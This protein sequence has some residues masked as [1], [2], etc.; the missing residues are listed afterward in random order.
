[1][2][3]TYNVYPVMAEAPSRLV[4]PAGLMM[5]DCVTRGRRLQL[6]VAL[7]SHRA[8]LQENVAYG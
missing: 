3:C 1:M 4:G 2:A 6:Q 7:H 8:Q 5:A